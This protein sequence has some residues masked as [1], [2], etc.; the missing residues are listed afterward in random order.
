MLNGTKSY[1]ILSYLYNMSK[2]FDIENG[3]VVLT[4][5]CLLTP[6]LKTIIDKHTDHINILSY[7]DF[8]TDP[9]GP[10]ADTPEADKAEIIYKDL[11]CR[12]DLEDP[13][14]I[15]AN[16]FCLDRRL[17]PTRRFYLDAK[18]GLEKMGGYLRTSKISSGRDGNDSTYLQM[19]KS[20]GKIT[21]EF[22]QLEKIYKEEVATLR[23][24]QTASYDEG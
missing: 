18:E 23:G 1:I 3:K 20:L 16:T 19:L 15:A 8:L 21:L 6:V 12:F 17:T 11:N 14:I 5:F 9:E 4:P 13:D 22:G 2:V 24:K 7:I 10:Y